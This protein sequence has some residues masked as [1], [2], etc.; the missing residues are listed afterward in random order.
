MHSLPPQLK[1][2]R[3]KLARS[4]NKRVMLLAG[5]LFAS[6]FIALR[7]TLSQTALFSLLATAAIAEIIGVICV[8]RLSKRQSIASG[9]S[10]PRCG[11]SLYDGRSNRLGI[12]GECP[13]CKQFII[14]QLNETVA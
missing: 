3:R 2:L 5:L 1:E 11:G 13:C 4:H 12:R 10:C 14:D 9:F 7:L 6:I 8:I